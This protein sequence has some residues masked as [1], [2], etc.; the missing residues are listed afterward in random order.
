MKEWNMVTEF[1]RLGLPILECSYYRSNRRAHGSTLVLW[2]VYC[3][4]YGKWERVLWSKQL[5]KD[6]LS[7]TNIWRGG[8]VTAVCRKTSGIFT[9]REKHQHQYHGYREERAGAD[10]FFTRAKRCSWQSTLIYFT[11][12]F[13]L[14]LM[15]NWVRFSRLWRSYEDVWRL[16]AHEWVRVHPTQLFR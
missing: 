12:E 2:F 8:I 4:A 9:T 14:W 15:Q 13:G 6:T 10:N 16:T 7:R 3:A 1:Q 5:F 11:D